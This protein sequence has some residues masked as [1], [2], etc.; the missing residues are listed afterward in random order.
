MLTVEDVQNK[1]GVLPGQVVQVQALAGDS[2]DNVPGVAGVGPKTAASLIQKYESVEGIYEH[3]DDITGAV[4]QKLRQDKDKAF[5]SLKLVQLAK[6]APLPLPV[7]EL[8]RQTP[9]REDVEA[10]CRDNGFFSLLP[11]LDKICQVI[12]TPTLPSFNYS[13]VQT[14]EQLKK[15]LDPTPSN[16]AWTTCAPE[17]VLSGIALA[18][19]RGEAC[20]IPLRQAAPQ[21]ALWGNKNCKKIGHNIKATWAL[22]CHFFGCEGEAWEDTQLLGYTACGSRQDLSLEALSQVFLKRS[23]SKADSP[24][25]QLA[26]QAYTTACLFKVLREYAQAPSYRQFDL[27]LMPVLASMEQQGLLLDPKRLSSLSEKLNAQMQTLSEQ[28][29]AQAGE[30]FNIN[31]PAQLGQILFDKMGLKCQKGKNTARSTDIEILEDLAQQ[32]VL[33]ASYLIEY[34]QCAKLKSTYADALLEQMDSKTCR[35]H[36]TFSQTATTTGRLSSSDPNLQNIPVRTPIGKDIRAAFIAPEGHVILSADYSQI[37]LRLMAHVAGVLALQKAF[38]QG[39][40]IHTTTARAVFKTDVVTPELRRRAKAINF[41]IMYGMSPYGLAR[42]LG[43]SNG[44]AKAYIDSYFEQYPQIREYMQKTAEQAEHDG[45][46]TTLFGRRCFVTFGGTA[47][48]KA[49]AIRAAINAPIQG[50]AADLIKKAMIEIAQE[51]TA[52]NRRTRMLLQIH[53]ELLFEVPLSEVD[54]VKPMIQQKMEHVTEL[55]VPLVVE[56]GVADNWLSAHE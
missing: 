7:S 27:P 36:T 19:E 17:G 10:F 24:E 8:K 3:I 35:I 51:L 28:I 21:A 9:V 4:G 18:T 15:W 34:R 53:D 44:E 30:T 16:V 20:Y 1:F 48:A 55:K 56:V 38:E 46:V 52:Q 54:I 40:D 29:Y 31:S 33:I 25:N 49:A 6:D 41:G 39:A 50:G 5:M 12:Q 14:A 42:Q 11:R 32:G 22:L 2:S 23:L 47:M 43:I 26:E 13:L 37:E 45:Y